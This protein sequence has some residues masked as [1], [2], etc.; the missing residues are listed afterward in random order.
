[1]NNRIKVHF[2]TGLFLLIYFMGN[3]QKAGK[4]HDPDPQGKGE[5]P[6]E[7]K[8][9]VEERE[10]A[11]T[12]KDCT[13]W[14]I[15]ANGCEAGL[16]RSDD[17]VLYRDY[18]GKLTYKSTAEKSEIV[19]KPKVPITME[20]SWDCINFWNYGAHWLWGEPDSRRA[21]RYFAL[22]ED[23]DQKVHEI[24]FVQSGNQGMVHKYWFMNHIKLPES[25]KRPIVFVG[26]KFAGRNVT[27]DEALNI[28]LGPIYAYEEILEPL[29]FDPYPEKLPFPTRKTTILP[30]NITLDFTTEAGDKNKSVEFTYSGDDTRLTYTIG[31]GEHFPFDIS[32]S[33]GSKL[34]LLNDANFQ[35]DEGEAQWSIDEKKL[36]RDT[37]F[38]RASAKVAGNIHLFRFYYTLQLKTLVVGMD[39]REKSVM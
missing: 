24:N 34:N 22:I 3:A 30:I 10:P 13:K 39:E 35:F 16:Y 5:K 32:L 29:Q 20:D 9:R 14:T 31:L 33:H 7:M 25:L 6:Y 23:A 17:Q 28:Y 15:E 27:D 8:D 37:L 21:F 4:N 1:M 12:F 38:I 36:E 2:L 26:I 18:V 11:I 19:L